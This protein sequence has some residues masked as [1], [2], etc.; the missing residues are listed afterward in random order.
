MP[1]ILLALLAVATAWGASPDYLAR[2]TS[3][4][5]SGVMTYS[6]Q[7]GRHQPDLINLLRK[8]AELS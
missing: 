7:Y 6:G 4:L 2:V 5:D 3:R 8:Q 1:T